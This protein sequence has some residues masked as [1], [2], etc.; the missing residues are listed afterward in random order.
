[1][2]HYLSVYILNLLPLALKCQKYIYL[3][4]QN[5]TNGPLKYWSSKYVYEEHY[6]IWVSFELADMI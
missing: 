3:A 4:I 6:Y 1:M 5:M 2:H